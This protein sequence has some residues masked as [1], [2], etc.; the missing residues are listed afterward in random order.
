MRLTASSS[1]STR[2]ACSTS[3]ASRPKRRAGPSPTSM[4]AR[5]ATTVV[6]DILFSVGRTGALTPF[7]VLEPVAVGGVTVS[8]STLHNMDEV[9]RLGIAAGDTVLIERAGEVI[10]HVLK[11]V[12]QG[13]DRRPVST[14]R[15]NARNAGASIHK[16]AGRGCLSLRQCGL[17]R[18]PQGVADSLCR[19]PR[20]EYRRPGRKNRG[21]AW[22]TAAW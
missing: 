6:K 11:V 7:A 3:W 8:R 4:P 19:P 21:P 22:W 13:K 20:D 9:G 15:R 1:R 2:L 10:P 12:E 18:A 5:Q 14:S 17:S 16:G